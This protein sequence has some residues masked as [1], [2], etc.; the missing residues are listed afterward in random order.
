MPVF[1]GHEWKSLIHSAFPAI[2]KAARKFQSHQMGRIWALFAFLLRVYAAPKE[3][4]AS[5]DKD[6]LRGLHKEFYRTYEN[7]F[8][9]E[10]CASNIH[11]FFHMCDLRKSGRMHKT[12]TE[13]FESFYARILESYQP[14]TRGI[15][16]QYIEKC[17]MRL[18]RHTEKQCKRKL[19]F[20]IMKKS[21]R[22]DD[23]LVVDRDFNFYKVQATTH[24]TAT[25]KKI[26]TKEWVC[27]GNVDLPFHLVGVR[28]FVRHEDYEMTLPKAHFTGKAALYNKHVL[29]GMQVDV[30]FA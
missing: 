13:A 15:A 22:V 14:G 26:M 17:Y 2:V 21:K 18:L 24:S 28:E 3:L 29:M 12:S 11:N 23:S 20:D 25:V 7:V 1:K 6:W 10:N 16:K 4:Y 30:L 8:G 9:K 5:F 27:P 19:H